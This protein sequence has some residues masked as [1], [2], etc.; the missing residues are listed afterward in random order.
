MRVPFVC[1]NWKMHKTLGDALALVDAVR[2]G[3]D[4]LDGVEVG[5]APP[6]TVLHAASH[7]LLGSKVCLAAQNVHFERQGAFTGE[8][9]AEMLADVGC[10]YVIVGHSER[11]QLF[12]ETDSSVGKKVGAALR[13]NLRVILCLGETLA[14]R[15]GNRT[16][17]VVSRQLEA[18]V[19]EIPDGGASDVVVAYE[20]VWA[21]GTG[22]NATPAQAQEVHAHLRGELARLLGN[23]V[24]QAMR[25]QYGGSVKA[26]NAK[27][28]FSQPDV[29][30]GLIG[31]ASLDA[32][33]FLAIARAAQR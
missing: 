28:L 27:E 17:E 8:V 29:D 6:F 10:R 20:P 1:G 32:K 23:E 18:G 15:E 30:G 3:A 24:A 19:K 14:E 7:R 9:S 11:R 22:K 16:L 2:A 21:I 33:S 12:G 31:G 13:N 26:D 25:L 4:T 5:I